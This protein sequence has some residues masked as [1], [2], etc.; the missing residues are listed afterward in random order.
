MGEHL[1][2]VCDI[3]CRIWKRE[4]QHVGSLDLDILDIGVFRY[5]RAFVKA[6]GFRST[7]VT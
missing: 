4:L 6:S 3:E 7:A 5:P 2:A 1:V